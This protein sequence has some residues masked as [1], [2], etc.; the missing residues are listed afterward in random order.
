MR[1]LV[2]LQSFMYTAPVDFTGGSFIAS[3]NA[4]TASEGSS[5]VKVSIKRD[6]IL[7]GFEYFSAV[8]SVPEEF[9]NV[10]EGNVSVVSVNI[11]DTTSESRFPV[12]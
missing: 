8:L 5:S 2:S 6:N 12:A 3:F 11:T 7:E 10:E 4:S 9:P 1:M